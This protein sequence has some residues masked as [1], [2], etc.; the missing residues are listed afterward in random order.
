MFTK[1]WIIEYGGGNI[2]KKG[3]K[4]R[5]INGIKKIDKTY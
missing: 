1:G 2:F 3:V 4:G 5:K